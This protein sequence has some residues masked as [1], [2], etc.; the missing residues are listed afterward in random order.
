[1]KE[2]MKKKGMLCLC[3]I[4][5]CLISVR[6][7][8]K[9]ESRA[10]HGRAV[11][12]EGEHTYTDEIKNGSG[13][14]ITKDGTEIT[15]NGSGLDELYL[16]V[17]ELFSGDDAFEWLKG[18]L[19]DH[20]MLKKAYDVL[21]TDSHGNFVKAEKK[22]TIT[23]RSVQEKNKMLVYH[24]NPQGVKTELQPEKAEK[25]GQELLIIT[26]TDI[27]YYALLQQTGEN[28]NQNTSSVTDAGGVRTGDSNEQLLWIGTAVL[29][30]TAFVSCMIIKGYRKGKEDEEKTS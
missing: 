1:M 30:M 21:F 9:E 13:T 10:V 7:Y 2:T 14:V 19:Q 24:V 28:K 29:S 11:Y 12:T 17:I 3:L 16:Y 5:G 8:A 18:E 20:G 26:G 15:V 23:I 4:L 22:F 6:A 27:N 25:D